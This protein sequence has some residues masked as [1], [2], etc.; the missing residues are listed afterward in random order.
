MIRKNLLVLTLA[1]ACGYTAYSTPITP[2]LLQNGDF[3]S[4]FNYWTTLGNPR[5]DHGYD[6]MSAGLGGFTN[7]VDA[8]DQVVGCHGGVSLD[9]TFYFQVVGTGTPATFEIQW[10]GVTVFTNTTATNG[11]TQFTLHNLF[12]TD[13]VNELTVYGYGNRKFYLDNMNLHEAP[14][15]PETLADWMMITTLVGLFV[16][17]KKRHLTPRKPPSAQ[18]V[19]SSQSSSVLGGKE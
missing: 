2:N 18:A 19:F 4:G 11:Y 1:V 5:L 3:E 13:G 9:L 10:N 15:V 12:T 17:A 6:N 14:S 16:V 8:L 7:S